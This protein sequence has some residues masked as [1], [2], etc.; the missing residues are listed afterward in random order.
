MQL[1][2]RFL[3]WRLD[4]GPKLGIVTDYDERITT[5]LENLGISHYF[6]VVVSSRCVREGPSLCSM[7]TSSHASYH[8]L[9]YREAGATKPDKRLFELAAEKAGVTDLSKAMH[10]GIDF[11]KDV[12]GAANAGF[13]P[14]WVVCPMFDILDPQQEAL[15]V[16]EDG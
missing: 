3:A 16:R 15:N 10:L 14:V 5:I 2:D 1:L 12:V 11:D 8:A 4:G 7:R 6:D 9:A 13:Q